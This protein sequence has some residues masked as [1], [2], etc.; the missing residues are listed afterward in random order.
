MFE[1]HFVV[2]SCI[3]NKPIDGFWWYVN[4]ETKYFLFYL[5]CIHKVTYCC[6]TTLLVIAVP[7]RFWPGWWKMLIC[8]RFLRPC[9]HSWITTYLWGR[10]CWNLSRESS[11]TTSCCM[12]V[13]RCRVSHTCVLWPDHTSYLACWSKVFICYCCDTCIK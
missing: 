10:T 1:L 2:K 9:N 6:V 7:W 3:E 12:L 4:T 5:Q 11:N 13:S 8:R